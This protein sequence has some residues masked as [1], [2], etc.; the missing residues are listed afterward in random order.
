ML[1]KLAG[2]E[3]GALMPQIGEAILLALV[4]IAAAWAG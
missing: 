2:E 3:R 1:V 4:T